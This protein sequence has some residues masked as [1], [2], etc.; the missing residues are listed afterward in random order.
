M[1][2][3][4]LKFSGLNSFIDP[5][6]VDF[7]KLSSGVF[8]IFGKTGSGKTTIL[9][10]IILALYGQI[11][12]TTK[13]V[14]FINS[15]SQEA[16]VELIFQIGD[17][18][19]YFVHRKYKR[20]KDDNSVPFA[21][22]GE[23]QG[24]N[25]FTLAE[26]VRDVDA[27]IKEI[28]GL[29]YN[30]F[31]KCIA[32][33]QGEFAGFLKSTSGER[34]EII[35][36][37]FSLQEY[38]DKLV[39]KV[40]VKYGD[41]ETKRQILEAQ[42]LML[43]PVTQENINE[44]ENLI[45]EKQELVDSLIK[46]REEKNKL[47]QDQKIVVELNERKTEI[48]KSLEDKYRQRGAYLEKTKNL[49]CHKRAK[50]IEAEIAKMKQLAEE[51]KT[52]KQE[53]VALSQNKIK[54]KNDYNEFVSANENFE[55]H[56]QQNLIKL[57]KKE[58]ALVGAVEDE[59]VMLSL[60]VSKESLE[61]DL[62]ELQESLKAQEIKCVGLENE[63][64]ETKK[65]IEE[66]S[67]ELETFE[68]DNSFELSLKEI[69]D[70]E[71][72]I[73]IYET[74][75]KQVEKLIENTKEEIEFSELEYSKLVSQEKLLNEKLKKCGLSVESLLAG[76]IEEGLEKLK[77]SQDVLVDIKDAERQISFIEQ[78]I[79]NKKSSIQNQ[80]NKI[81]QIEKQQDEIDIEIKK[82]TEQIK[83]GAGFEIN[84]Y[85]EKLI[86][87]FAT[88]QAK[89][90]LIQEIIKEEEAEINKLKEV[91]DKTY[92]KFVDNNGRKK[93]AFNNLKERIL[94]M[95]NQLS[96]SV[97]IS[98]NERAEVVG[99]AKKKV[100]FGTRISVYKEQLQ[101]L[102]DLL[103]GLQKYR[104]EHEFAI[105]NARERLEEKNCIDSSQNIV[106]LIK[107]NNDK[108]KEM[109]VKQSEQ[110]GLLSNLQIEK[111]AVIGQV[112]NLVEK[113]N[114]LK[115][116]IAQKEKAYNEVVDEGTSASIA[117][118]KVRESLRDLIERFDYNKE[119]TD[120][121]K[122]NADRVAEEYKV[123]STILDD[124]TSELS[125]L[126]FNLNGKIFN[127]GFKDV[128]DAIR[129]ITNDENV[130]SLEI[131]VNEYNQSVLL[132]EKELAF[133]TESL[134]D[135]IVEVESFDRLKQSIENITSTISQEQV[136]LGTLISSHK[137]QKED[138][139]K[140]VK[141][142]LELPDVIKK[143]D[144]AKELLGLLR[145]KAL[146]EFIA[147]E[148]MIEITRNASNKLNMLM[149]GRYDLD[150]VDGN[151]AVYD[152]FN[153]HK[154]RIVQ[155]LSGGETFLVSLALALAMSE[156]ISLSS[157]RNME[158]FFLDEGFG[159]LDSE[160]VENVISALYKLESHNLKIGLISH[161]KE[162]ED[163][164]KNKIMVQS[165]TDNEGSSLKIVYN[166]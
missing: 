68:M 148:Y 94:D 161:V 73:I 150:F 139:S 57:S 163:E 111:Q 128:D 19:I 119:K 69:Q 33:P 54:T 25:K 63:L 64:L 96:N 43:K 74:L 11:S 53:V 8:G 41:L 26:G 35:S 5:Q 101:L 13:A 75:E 103:F 88:L 66:I 89:A 17:G 112:D 36:N 120:K 47:F 37:I 158:F 52:L 22:F 125:D 114:N 81:A 76:K 151:F 105:F 16:D 164:I 38:G 67:K 116:Q 80:L 24:E 162:L 32:L 40:K 78:L 21:W 82:V 86:K 10:A 123:K 50:S 87:K 131:E 144:D 29:S 65:T 45:K 97:G 30:E 117:L 137:T 85:K 155:T 157:N 77:E 1:K 102:L 133:V 138:Y 95:I 83:L 56:Y 100:E 49:E 134:G 91:K 113:I 110:V 99:L 51:T 152:N 55:K 136:L 92:L 118:K 2:P 23:V 153:D 14:D 42:K 58:V 160:L 12:K 71:S 145:G 27:Y 70:I 141:I 72:E 28:V 62:R 106:E 18:K 15:K 79:S 154:P 61:E 122:Q 126:S 84:N 108:L 156:I 165:A 147:E 107:Q 109:L 159:T 143:L 90:E 20:K 98:G 59:M 129:W 166:L 9:D 135:R 60:K 124:K 3:I 115:D 104:A 46:E 146:V 48:V 149:D 93:E 39:D 4:K 121:L 44:T 34:T 140:L 127:L 130:L 132:L 31:S 142:E 7:N 6:E